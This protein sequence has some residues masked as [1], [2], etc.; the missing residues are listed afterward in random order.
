MNTNVCLF[1]QLFDGALQGLVNLDFSAAS[2]NSVAPLLASV[3][4]RWM[5]FIRPSKAGEYTF[6]VLP[7]VLY[8]H[9]QYVKLLFKRCCCNLN[10]LT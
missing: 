10:P 1:L 6:S 3:S 4:I 7:Q 5:G 9:N 2:G 8:V